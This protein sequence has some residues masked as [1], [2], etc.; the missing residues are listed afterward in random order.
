[1]PATYEA[2]GATTLGSASSTITFS[3]I[4]NTYT[5]LKLILVPRVQ[6]TNANIVVT[7]NGSTTTYSQNN[8]YTTGSSR[9][10]DRLTGNF[11]GWY[12]T[13]ANLGSTT[14]PTLYIVDI[15]SYTDSTFKGSLFT[16]SQDQNGSGAV[17]RGAG[18]WRNTSAVTSVGLLQSSNFSAGTTA[19]LYGI[20]S[21]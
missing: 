19:T 2:I 8:I 20:K 5:D 17:L 11:D 14:I 12:I 13:Q 10:A 21:A 3:S 15:F 4:P 16:S 6:A 7:L 1:M 18:L 9:T